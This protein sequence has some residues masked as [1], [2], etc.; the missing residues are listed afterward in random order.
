[1]GGEGRPCQ[2]DQGL[3]DLSLRPVT[4]IAGRGRGAVEVKSPTEH[5]CRHC[6]TLRQRYPVSQYRV[7]CTGYCF[8]FCVSF[9]VPSPPRWESCPRPHL[10]GGDS[11]P[12][13]TETLVYGG[14]DC[15]VVFLGSTP[16]RPPRTPVPNKVTVV[17]VHTTGC[18]QSGHPS[19]CRGSV[20]MS[21][22]SSP[23]LPGCTHS[24][25]PLVESWSTEYSSRN[26]QYS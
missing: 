4:K 2:R 22:T 11:R 23:V 21:K 14:V 16:T 24:G 6:G 9:S 10:Q 25:H 19:N 26:T 1:M 20:P 7:T 3:Y 12:P 17:P 5:L 15:R 8:L 13:G 18:R